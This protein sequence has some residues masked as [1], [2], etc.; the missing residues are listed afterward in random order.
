MLIKKSAKNLNIKIKT[1]KWGHSQNGYG[2]NLYV[3][4]SNSASIENWYNEY[5]YYTYSSQAC[6]N[7]QQCGHYTQ[8]VWADS[9]SVGCGYAICNPQTMMGYSYNYAVY[10]V[11]NYD[12][13]GNYIGEYPYTKASSSSAVAT[14]CPSGYTGSQSTGLCMRNDGST[15]IDTTP[16]TPTTPAPTTR[17]PTSSGATT[18]SPT[19]S[20]ATTRSPTSG[21]GATTTASSSSCTT[22]AVK[23]RVAYVTSSWTTVSQLVWNNALSVVKNQTKSG[24]SIS[25]SYSSTYFDIA[26]T[27]YTN[28][29][30]VTL[31]SYV[32]KSGYKTQLNNQ[33]SSY[34]TAGSLVI[35]VQPITT[36]SGSGQTYTSDSQDNTSNS[37]NNSEWWV[38]FV[39]IL[40]GLLLGFGCGV[41][42]VHCR[43][44]HKQKEEQTYVKMVDF[45]AQ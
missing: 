21:S 41:A 30:A 14:N 29:D 43:N 34:I 3:S 36:A 32:G 13:P 31:Q 16:T 10:L 2:E 40:I 1:G 17:S 8:V 6:A 18:R 25:G 39:A 33:I 28:K 44:K 19:S 9:T 45:V 37:S 5:Q 22:C 7:G 35:T 27:T 11:C 4:F 12:P 42:F 15:G 20:G 23:W 38:W 24:Y 26:V